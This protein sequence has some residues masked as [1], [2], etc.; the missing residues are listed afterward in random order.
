MVLVE[1][2]A[3][4]GAGKRIEDG[5]AGGT[6]QTR[7][8][9]RTD[10]GGGLLLEGMHVVDQV[11]QVFLQLRVPRRGRLQGQLR[12]QPRRHRR[13]RAGVIGCDWERGGGVEMVRKADA[14]ARE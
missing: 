10:H 13:Q 9:A 1:D 4:G 11:L 3:K 6:K 12:L 7:S 14:G 2:E 8:R 5:K